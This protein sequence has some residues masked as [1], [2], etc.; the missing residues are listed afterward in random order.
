M[1]SLQSLR[2]VCFTKKILNVKQSG[3]AICKLRAY[4]ESGK[5]PSK[6][7][8]Y[9]LHIK[10]GGK[11]V[12][13]AGF[14]L[15][16]QYSD[17]SV[18]ASHLFTRKSA[19]IF[20]VSHML[21]TNVKGKDCIAWFESICPVDLKGMAVGSS[22]LTVFLNNKGGIIDDLIVTKVNNETL[23]IVS[24]AGRLDVDKEHM[25][26]TS[27]IFRKKG[28]DVNIEF[29]DVNQRG[30]IAVQGPKAAAAVQSLT[31]IQMN[32]LF[33]MTSRVGSVAG[34]PCRVTRCGYTGEDGVEISMAAGEAGLVTEA[35]LQSDDVKLAGLGARDSLR[36]EAGLCLYGNDIDES[37][38]PVEANLTW[39]ISKPRR[40]E[41]N[42]PGAEII[43]NQIKGGVSKRRVGIRMETGAPARKD[44]L[45]KDAKTGEV[46]GKVTS[47]CPS[48]SLGGN[49]A[50][51]YVAEALKKAGTDL[52]VNIRGKDAPCLVE[53]M[54]FVPSH[55]YVKK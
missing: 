3:V 10:Y 12:D 15:P 1:C 43:L 22:S 6:T 42:F 13:F 5:Q 33:F 4:S 52:L 35:L 54:P 40:A 21:Q 29:W 38:T 11:V 45:L 39:L 30:L 50:M 53:K 46:V 41:A 44:A 18:S 2:R 27:E 9:D 31:D 34:V 24:N 25:K 55:Y 14:L 7:P 19:S 51:G 49:V 8:L 26:E 23:Y 28:K 20:D 32:D 37:V 36:L 48:P 47:G 16:V 17:Q